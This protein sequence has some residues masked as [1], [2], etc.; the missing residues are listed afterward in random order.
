MSHILC[1]IDDTPGARTARVMLHHAGKF[2]A[3][4]RSMWRQLRDVFLDLQTRT[5]ATDPLRC[6]VV[7]GADGHFCAGGD[8]S[9]YPAF[10]F[11]P[12]SLRAFHEEDVWGALSAMLTC[13]C[14]LVAAIDGHCMGAG[15]EIASCCDIRIA[16]IVSRY[17]APIGKLGFPMAP[18]ETALL[19]RTLGETCARSMLLEAAVYSATDMLQRGFLTRTV[20][21]AHALQTECERTVSAICRLGPASLQMNKQGLRDLCGTKIDHVPANAYAYA[22]SGEHREGICAFL[23]KRKPHF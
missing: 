2:N 15:I 20:S 23:E 18:R 12:D 17:G 14:P 13:N 16:T 4:S 21:D 3:M 1:E 5:Q 7:H 10:R 22:S 19:T 9:E 6:V 11:A 8:I